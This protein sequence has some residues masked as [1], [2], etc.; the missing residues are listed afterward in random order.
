MIMITHSMAVLEHAEHAFLLCNGHIIDKGTVDKISGYF[1]RQLH[2][3]RPRER[4]GAR[5]GDD[6][7]MSDVATARALLESLGDFGAHFT[8]DDVAHL[9]VHGNE[10]V[11]VAPRSRA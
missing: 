1:A 3:L 5:R 9:E 11:G 6:A 10:V 8:G 7:G 2:P 4:A